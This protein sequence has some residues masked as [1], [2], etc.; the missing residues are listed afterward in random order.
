MKSTP[1]PWT[2]VGVTTKEITTQ[3]GPSGGMQYDI[4]VPAGTRCH[5]LDG[6]SSPWVV[7]D[8]RFIEDKSSLL[9]SDADHYGIRID[10]EM[11]ENISPVAKC[12]PRCG[13]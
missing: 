1:T 8:L 12:G 5:K 3:F 2:H 11:L 7:A 10:E 13:M 9:Y 4:T 6:G